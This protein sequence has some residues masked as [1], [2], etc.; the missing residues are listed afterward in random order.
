MSNVYIIGANSHSKQI[1]D[2]FELNNI[3][4]MGIFDDH[5]IGLHYK[6]YPIIGQIKDIINL[7][8]Q[9]SCLFCAID[10]NIL[11]QKICDDYSFYYQFPNCIHPQSFISNS[12]KLGCGN[13][14][15]AFVSILA[16]SNIGSFNIIND[17]ISIS[18]DVQ[19]ENY[20]Y[21]S[22]NVSLGDNIILKNNIFVGMNA[23]ILPNMEI[24]NDCIISDGSING[25]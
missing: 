24:P 10:D 3:H 16:D 13:Y 7:I 8:P 9:N 6:D 5:K 1:I 11:R 23:I 2:V 20:N 15:G 4:I 18:C 19:I 21:L 12:V 14:I 17:S 25:D 22:S